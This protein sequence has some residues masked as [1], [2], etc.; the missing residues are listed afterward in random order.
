M[1]RA[2]CQ[3]GF[4]LFVIQVRPDSLFDLQIQAGVTAHRIQRR[5]VTIKSQLIFFF[6]IHLL[7]I[8]HFL[9]YSLV[10]VRVLYEV[11]KF[12]EFLCDLGGIERRL[13]GLFGRLHGW[14]DGAPFICI[15]SLYA[16]LKVLFGGEQ[17]DFAFGGQTGKIQRG[18]AVHVYLVQQGR[19]IR[20]L[21][22]STVLIS[23]VV[24]HIAAVTY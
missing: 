8:L 22:F 21:V 15:G 6:V 1:P 3:P 9:E 24:A 11:G 17:G 7:N 23:R 13:L 14:R 16:L 2:L 5:Q 10:A 4:A 19:S 18:R 20:P 12:G